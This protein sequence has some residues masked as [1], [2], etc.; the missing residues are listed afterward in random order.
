MY[1]LELVHH[2]PTRRHILARAQDK[3][4]LIRYA[5]AVRRAHPDVHHARANVSIRKTPDGVL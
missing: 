2:S 5:H 3:Q 4:R 1:V